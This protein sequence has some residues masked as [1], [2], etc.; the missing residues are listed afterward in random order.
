MKFKEHV[1]HNYKLPPNIIS[2][3][4]SLFTSKLWKAL[5]KSFGT[6]SAASTAYHPQ[7]DSQSDIAHRKV[8]EM[9]RSFANYILEELWHKPENDSIRRTH[10]E[11]TFS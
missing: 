3:H 6:K 1:Y 5:F 2:D 9:I 7:T 11:Q 4:G 8:E 10:N